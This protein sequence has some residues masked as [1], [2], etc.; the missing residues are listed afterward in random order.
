MTALVRARANTIE[1]VT[2]KLYTLTSG[3]KAWKGGQAFLDPSTGKV[4]PASSLPGMLAIGLFDRDVD[5]SAGEKQVNINFGMEREFIWIANDV[6]APVPSSS[7][8][9]F[10][11]FLDDQTVTALSGGTL[12]GRVWDVQTGRG[13]LVERLLSGSPSYGAGLTAGTFP[14]YVAN[15]G[16]IPSNPVSGSIFDIG[17][18]AAPVNV[19]LPATAREGT[20][21]RF[22]ADGT[23]NAHT[24]TYRDATGPANL[25]TALTAAKRHQVDVTFLNSKWTANAYVSP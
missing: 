22:V 11:Y 25:T 10:C 13:V 17:T 8:G 5:A 12:A 15:D 2:Y 4:R 14:A 7:I 19:T 23:K 3:L 18:T 20:M 21:L 1:R 9:A 16:I 6:G 24:V